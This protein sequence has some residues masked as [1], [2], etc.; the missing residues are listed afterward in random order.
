MEFHRM[1]GVASPELV[2]QLSE[3]FTHTD[4]PC[5]QRESNAIPQFARQPCLL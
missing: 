3:A 4:P 2:Q 5:L 1:A